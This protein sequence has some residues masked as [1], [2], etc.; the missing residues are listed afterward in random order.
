M[1]KVMF[2]KGTKWFGYGNVNVV[3]NIDHTCWHTNPIFEIHHHNL[4]FL[5]NKPC[6]EFFEHDID[7][8]HHFLKHKCFS[9]SPNDK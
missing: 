6:H 1:G 7:H 9:A 4:H 8:H 5:T 3:N 2:S